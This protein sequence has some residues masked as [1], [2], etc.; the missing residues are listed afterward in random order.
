MAKKEA[1]QQPKQTE[2]AAVLGG[3]LSQPDNVPSGRDLKVKPKDE[4][5]KD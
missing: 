3:G 5:K 2:E 1:P 4:D